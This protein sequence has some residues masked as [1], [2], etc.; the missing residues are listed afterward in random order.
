MP[1]MSDCNSPQI[2]Q[3][4]PSGLAL[5][6]TRAISVPLHRKWKPFG[7]VIHYS[8]KHVTLL[9]LSPLLEN[10]ITHS[11]CEMDIPL[12]FWLSMCAAHGWAG[13]VFNKN[14]RT[15]AH[16][17]RSPISQSCGG[18]KAHQ[19]V[20]IQV[21]SIVFTSDIRIAEKYDLSDEISTVCV[22]AFIIKLSS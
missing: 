6:H 10:F 7:C 22:R 15:P 11:G 8:G 12:C 4:S 14:T 3:L 13:C 19:I 5:N 16:S 20:P 21:P 2:S 9:R 17:C 1:F 18:S